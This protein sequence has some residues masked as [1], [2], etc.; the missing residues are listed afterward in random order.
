MGR[1]V[2]EGR[3]GVIFDCRRVNRRSGM[4]WT[5]GKKR[6]ETRRVKG[7][8]RDPGTVRSE[9]TKNPCG[10]CQGGAP[11]TCP[12]RERRGR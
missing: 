3:V 4:G 11:E 12:T 8:T 10:S 1:F 5:G 7:F 2:L 9:T 6:L